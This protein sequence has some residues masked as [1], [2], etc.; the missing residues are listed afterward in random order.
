MQAGSLE[1]MI[2]QCSLLAKVLYSFLQHRACLGEQL[3][4]LDIS[5]QLKSILN[6]V[7]QVFK[8]VRPRRKIIFPF[9]HEPD[10]NLRMPAILR[11]I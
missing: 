3:G 8:E 1:T 4:Q 9:I 11:V 5:E 10:E 6:N 7:S 2:Q